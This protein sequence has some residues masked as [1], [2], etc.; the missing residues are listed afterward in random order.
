MD[1]YISR[2]KALDFLIP[3]DGTDIS[4][5][6]ARTI[7]ERFSEHLQG[8]PAEDVIPTSSV[9]EKWQDSMY[10]IEQANNVMESAKRQGWISVEERLP[11]AYES[12]LLYDPG[13]RLQQKVTEGYI[14][15][16][17]N[18]YSVDSGYSRVF[19]T[20]WMPMP[21]PPKEGDAK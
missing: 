7:G 9:K 5:K 3:L 11:V 21:E 2:Q 13:L 4:K 14:G 18:F 6:D 10:L 15:S 19:P 1:D 8:I 20:Y 16:N 17:G 12:V